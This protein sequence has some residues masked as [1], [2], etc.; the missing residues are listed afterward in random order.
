MKKY[1]TEN[2]WT[3]SEPVEVDGYTFEKAQVLYCDCGCVYGLL[4]VNE[5]K[6]ALRMLVIETS[7]EGHD[8]DHDPVS[9]GEIITVPA[10]MGEG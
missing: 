8:G 1:R 7:D 5:D 4:G 9:A 6:T 10:Q 3:N 2:G